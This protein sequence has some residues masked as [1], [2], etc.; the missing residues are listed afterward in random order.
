MTANFLHP[1]NDI[2]VGD[3]LEKDAPIC[4]KCNRR[5]WLTKIET[6][7]SDAGIHSTRQFECKLC[8]SRQGV[9]EQR[10]ETISVIDR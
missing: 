7:I 3:Q 9:G 5:M 1:S 10:N 6:K 8:G 4:E 2:P